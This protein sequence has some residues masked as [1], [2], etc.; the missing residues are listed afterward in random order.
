MSGATNLTCGD[1]WVGT[2]TETVRRVKCRTK[3]GKRSTSRLWKELPFH[4]INHLCRSTD[5][6]RRVHQA[7]ESGP[8]CSAT[9]TRACAGGMRLRGIP[10]GH[11]RRVYG[12]HDGSVRD[13]HRPV[14][15]A[16]AN[17]AACAGRSAASPARN[18]R[19]RER[20]RQ[21]FRRP[22]FRVKY[23]ACGVVHSEGDMG[24]ISRQSARVS[25]GNRGS[26]AI[27]VRETLRRAG[28]AN[29]YST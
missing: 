6:C 2:V 3:T 18:T 21:R 29:D 25:G 26:L 20:R 12:G 5:A 11:R 7:P 14:T 24:H 9:D 8:G 22:E 13:G 19:R 1:W 10:P 16:A 17:A 4:R 27:T 23:R 15:R 28:P